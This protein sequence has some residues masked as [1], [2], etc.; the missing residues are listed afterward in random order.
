MEAFFSAIFSQ[1]IFSHFIH[2]FVAIIIS[3][4]KIF[5][6]YFFILHY[7]TFLLPSDLCIKTKK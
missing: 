4:F 1:R 6:Y 2:P 3:E 7:H 5:G